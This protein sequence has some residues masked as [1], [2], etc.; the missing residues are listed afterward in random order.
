MATVYKMLDDQA[1]RTKHK[2]VCNLCWGDLVV[3]QTDQVDERTGFLLSDVYC[4]NPG[5]TGTGFVTRF[6][7]ERRVNGSSLE[8]QDAYENLAELLGLKRKRIPI[9][10]ALKELGF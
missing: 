10:Q 2:Y 3:E 1:L 6:Y 8:Y 5:C 7:A 4:G 9:D